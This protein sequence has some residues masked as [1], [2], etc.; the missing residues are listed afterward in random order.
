MCNWVQNFAF[1]FS[2]S[3][4]NAKLWMKK[5]I[6]NPLSKSLCSWFDCTEVVI[7]TN[8]KEKEIESINITDE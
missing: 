7:L 1:I 2:E 3:Y 5:K 6:I 4:V 8:G